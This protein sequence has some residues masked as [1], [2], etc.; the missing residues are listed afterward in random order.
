MR[1][2][3]A[4]TELL[5][6]PE[7]RR[8][9]RPLSHALGDGVAYPQHMSKRLQILVP[10]DEMEVIKQR[11]ESEEL[12]VGEYIRRSLR[13]AAFGPPANSVFTKLAFIREA[14]K[15]SLP[16]ADI[17]QMNREIARG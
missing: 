9:V 17:E 5:L 4:A 6:D 15:L 10:D 7:P 2:F 14:A 1:R 3:I 8:S 12:S 13:D 16:V 11:A